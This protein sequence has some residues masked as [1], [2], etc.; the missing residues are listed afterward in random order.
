[1]PHRMLLTLSQKHLI[2]ATSGL[3]MMNVFHQSTQV[4]AEQHTNI[5]STLHPMLMLST[6]QLPQTTQ[7]RLL[8]PQNPPFRLKFTV[9]TDVRLFRCLLKRKKPFR[10]IPKTARILISVLRIAAVHHMSAHLRI[11]SSPLNLK[12]KPS[13]KESNQPFHASPMHTILR[14]H[15]YS[16][17]CALKTASLYPLK[18]VLA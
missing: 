14:S 5:Q 11:I 17:V 18:K 10:S 13:P 2:N 8:L 3:R 9:K 15:P 4:H 12:K 1:M 6:L 16:S 7:L